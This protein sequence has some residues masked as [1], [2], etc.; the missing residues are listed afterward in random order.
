MDT[1]IV[2]RVALAPFPV[3]IAR[4]LCSPPPGAAGAAAAPDAAGLRLP[5]ARLRA[6]GTLAQ[7]GTLWLGI[8]GKGCEKYTPNG[9]I[10]SA[11]GV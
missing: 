11:T 9:V 6:C 1:S 2:F 7:G 3:A 4:G 8:H 10:S 5:A